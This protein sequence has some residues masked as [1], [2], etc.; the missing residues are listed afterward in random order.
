MD[1]QHTRTLQKEVNVTLDN[2]E[3]DWLKI[4][5]DGK[6]GPLTRKHA[7]IAGSWQG[8][9]PENLKKIGDGHINQ[10]LFDLLT[11][12]APR[13]KEMVVRHKQRLHHFEELRFHHKHP[14]QI[15]GIVSFDGEQVPG[16]IAEINQ[17]ARD[18]GYWHGEVISGVRSPEYSEHLCIIMCG[19]PTC[20][21]RC[22]G[23]FSNHACPPTGKGVK[24]EGA[25]DVTDPAG[26]DRFCREHN[27]PL[28]G[29]GRVL[30]LDLNHFSHAGN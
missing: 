5:V 12:Q 8:V 25:E 21:G 27:K 13:T 7:R 2:A 23:R 28:I 10:R 11:H 20:S 3:L 22:G 24:Y 30:P 29:N 4:P 9:S 18:A 15:E 26:L 14:P 19:Q 1:A 6:F 16:W 17:E